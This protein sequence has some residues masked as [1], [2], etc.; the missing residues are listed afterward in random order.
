MYKD[1]PPKGIAPNI[2]KDTTSQAVSFEYLAAQIIKKTN[3]AIDKTAQ[4]KWV[5]PLTGSLIF[6][7]K[8]P[9]FKGTNYYPLTI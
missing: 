5:N 7:I 6:F 4:A 8:P 3:P 2:E 1:L 9:F